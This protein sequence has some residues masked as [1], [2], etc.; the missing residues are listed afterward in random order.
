MRR[1]DRVIVLPRD[2]AICDHTM[3]VTSAS[4]LSKSSDN[5]SVAVAQCRWLSGRVRTH[6]VLAGLRRVE[7]TRRRDAAGVEHLCSLA[8]N[9]QVTTMHLH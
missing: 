8:D 3:Y 4:A 5:A 7:C 1:A 6:H 9:V 2:R